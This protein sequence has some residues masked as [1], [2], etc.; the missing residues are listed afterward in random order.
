MRKLRQNLGLVYFT[1]RGEA[2]IEREKG[3]FLSTSGHWFFFTALCSMP[4]LRPFPRFWGGWSTLPTA[5]PAQAWGLSPCL[6]ECA[7]VL[8]GDRGTKESRLPRGGGA[9]CG[10]GGRAAGRQDISEVPFPPIKWATY[11]R[12]QMQQSHACR[13]CHSKW[14]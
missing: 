11:E 14:C 4:F 10:E 3:L 2:S 5:C 9:W 8:H 7:R 1:L 6:W 12:I 13:T